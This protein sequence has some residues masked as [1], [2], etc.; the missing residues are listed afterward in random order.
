VEN[1][2]IRAEGLVK[3]YGNAVLAVD[4][5]SFTVQTGEIYGLLGPNGAGKSTTVAMLTTL[6]LPTAGRA[7][8]GG[9]D[10]VERAVHVRRVAGVALQEIGLDP[11]MKPME[12]LTI[13]AR[14]FGTPA[15][16]ARRRAGQLLEVVGLSDVAE[17]R[18]GQFSG[19]MRR[20]LDLAMALAHGPGPR[21]PAGYLV[22]GAAA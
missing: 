5:V 16:V 20:R 18:V 22:G 7:S 6:Q 14:L 21:Q 19:G 11:L 13:Q 10:V 2:Q 17:R 1:R 12:L 8:V 15:A 4:T 3:R 9:F